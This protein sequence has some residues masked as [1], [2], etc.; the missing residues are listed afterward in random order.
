MADLPISGLDE[1]T[2]LADADEFVFVD[3]SDLSVDP[4]GKTKRGLWSTIKTALSS[5][6][7]ALV[8]AHAQSDITNLTSDLAGKVPT[9]RTVNGHALSAD[10]TVTAS[11][12]GADSTGTASSAIATHVGQ[13]D[14]HTQYAQES[15]LGG[16]ALLNVGT[17]T[18]T[19]AA[20]D[21]THTGLSVQ[22]AG[23]PSVRALGTG[24]TEACA[25]ND[26]RLSDAR[27]PTA[28]THL[29]AAGATDVTASAGEVNVLAG[30]TAGS[31]IASKALVLDA[32]KNAG[33]VAAALGYVTTGNGNGFRF[34]NNTGIT[35]SSPA[36][37]ASNLGNGQLYNFQAA[38]FYIG[39]GLGSLICDASGNVRVLNSAQNA[40]RE[41]KAAKHRADDASGTN[42]AGTTTYVGP[43]QSTGNATPAKAIFQG[44]ATGSTGATAQPLVDVFEITNSLLV[45][46]TDSVNLAFGS[47]GGTKIGTATTQKIGFWNATPVVQ[48][49]LATGGGATA[50]NIISLL[51]TLGLCRQ[52]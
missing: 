9:T 32:S 4:D 23:T 31:A 5:V 35:F 7:A 44:T 46:Y 6:F 27:T 26:A 37:Q 52:S 51:Q 43:G 49:V 8:H 28:H 42:T 18:G 10:V 29:L 21:H 36:L 34:A 39:S 2:V 22:A 15:A 13:P 19:V 25:G 12:V 41:I 48:Q 40:M 50:D 30:A 1:G 11:D 24:G 17:S 3:K 38:I 14:P 20:G 45:S 16:A 33:S 47:T